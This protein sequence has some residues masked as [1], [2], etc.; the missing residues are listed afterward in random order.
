MFKKILYIA[1]ISLMFAVPAISFSENDIS[2]LEIERYGKNYPYESLG[3]RL[4]RLETEYFGM[5]QSGDIDSR[6]EN[7]MRINQN[8]QNGVNFKM[9]N[10]NK[11][12]EKGFFKNIFKDFTSN[13]RNN[14][15]ITG[16]T[17]PMNTITSTGYGDLY[18]RMNHSQWNYPHD[19]G[20]NYRNPYYKRTPYVNRDNKFISKNNERNSYVNHRNYRRNNNYNRYDKVRNNSFYYNPQYSNMTDYY[21]PPEIETKTSIHILD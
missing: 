13:F 14:G 10:K 21:L 11:N 1:V 15:S 3:E 4:T 16:Y 8:K 20:Y 2:I 5:T 12:E 18:E 9:G 7:L 6:I 19:L 17:A